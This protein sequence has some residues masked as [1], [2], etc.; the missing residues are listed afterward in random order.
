M[1]IDTSN[2]T[3]GPPLTLVVRGE[4]LIPKSERNDLNKILPRELSLIFAH[5]KFTSGTHQ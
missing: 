4:L 2:Q 3:K 5:L 1:N